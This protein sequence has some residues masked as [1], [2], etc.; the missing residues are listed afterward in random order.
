MSDCPAC[1]APGAEPFYEQR[2]VPVQSVALLRTREEALAFPRGDVVLALCGACGFVFNEAYDP[3]L[4]D[5]SRPSEESQAFSPRFREF[6]RELAERL[7]E[8][9]HVRGM[10]VLEAGCGRG[11]F[12]I[13]ICE[14]GGN[15]GVGIDPGWTP[16][17]LDVPAGV[18]FVRAAYDEQ[19]A[20]R[21]ADLVL[22]RHTLEHIA[23]VRGFVEVLRRP[24]AARDGAVVIEVPDV[25]RVLTEVAYWD[26]YYEHCSYFTEDS[27]RGVAAR[28]G[29][30]VTASE[31]LF[32]GQYI[33]V[34]ARP[35]APREASGGSI[36]AAVE[37]FAA[38]A[39]AAIAAWRERL[40]GGQRVALWG[41]S[42]KAVAF[43]TAV[44]APPDTAVVDINPFRQGAFLPG[45]GQR[46][47]APEELV[48]A[49]PELV[50][51]MNA[52]YLGEIRGL[53]AALGLDCELAAVA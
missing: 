17:R 53:L 32:D 52:A 49:R 11:D 28:A 44:G 19:Q 8:R 18:E 36:A 16:G 50:V 9:H 15:R 24:A 12:L 10:D 7:V 23:D 25:L 46:V 5:Y 33:V 31:L 21:D 4:Q 30:E 29:L 14:L 51:A 37:G 26:V 6:S 22:C 41:G 13:E 40:V 3:A 20:A 1:G 48:E 34:E 27:L 43:L 39:P 35:A 47:L 2:G 38:G 42:S 45:G